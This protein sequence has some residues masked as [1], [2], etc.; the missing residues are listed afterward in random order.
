MKK[1]SAPIIILTILV[2]LSLSLVGTSFYLLQKERVKNIGLAEKLEEINAKQLVTEK[3]LNESE[4][5]ILELQSKL[6]EA[7]QKIDLLNVDLEQEKTAR[8]EAVAKIEQVRVDLEQQQKLR[9][10]LEK[11]LNLAQDDVK[12]TQEQLKELE[13]QRVKLETKVKDLESKSQ[14]VELG[15]IVV[16][17]EAGAP[18]VAIT[19]VPAGNMVV[20]APAGKG[21]VLVV[22]KDYNFLVFNLGSKDNINVGDVFSVYRDNKY[23][24]DVKVEKVH[25]AMSA[26]G[27]VSAD[28]KDK[29]IEGDTVQK[30]VK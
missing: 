19:A 21:K 30:T 1:G 16:S 13:T 22:N 4:R 12:K 14:G 7:R 8:Q 29:V 28:I 9:S 23:L 10:D 26:A 17:Q 11:K 27:F 6:Q 24:G 18:G 25:E 20:P 2:L 5:I 3:K 15:K